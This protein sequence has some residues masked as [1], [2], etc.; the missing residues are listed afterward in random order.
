MNCASSAVRLVPRELSLEVSME[1]VVSIVGMKVLQ[2][3]RDSFSSQVLPEDCEI[4]HLPMLS[5][6]GP[7]VLTF[8]FNTRKYI[9]ID[10]D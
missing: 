10:M 1:S 9:W 5:A 3:C 8:E 6:S 7:S 4:S 2:D